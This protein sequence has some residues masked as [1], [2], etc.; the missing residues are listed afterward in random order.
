LQSILTQTYQHYKKSFFKHYGIE[1]NVNYVDHY[2]EL[3]DIDDNH[4]AYLLQFDQGHIVVGLNYNI[5]RLSIKENI[6][7]HN[8]SDIQYFINNNFFVK[9][10]GDFIPN[11]DD[12]FDHSLLDG[13]SWFQTSIYHKLDQ[14]T[15]NN[16]TDFRITRSLANNISNQ[17]GTLGSYTFYSREQD[18]FDCGPLAAL[19]LLMSYELSGFSGIVNSR[20]SFNELVILRSQMNWPKT[21]LFKGVWPSEFL[22]GVNS[23]LPNNF[24]MISRGTQIM[25]FS[26]VVGM[27]YN[28]NI[29][30]TAHYAVIIGSATAK[31]WW[32]FNHHFDII[33]HWKATHHYQE[34][35]VGNRKSGTPAYYFV[36]SN[37]R[38]EVW[39]LQRYTFNP[40]G[41]GTWNWEYI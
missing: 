7:L 40:H 23:Y 6:I 31:N 2:I 35:F 22:A 41:G 21:G 13:Q 38:Q 11:S 29:P 5:Y 10:N 1:W 4:T 24:R 36:N 3:H 17:Q 28:A 25:D 8:S 33:S 14:A 9:K 16:Y 18:D 19:N 39:A 30:G 26:P 34:G 27:F 15:M 37:F 20:H 32:I 12:F